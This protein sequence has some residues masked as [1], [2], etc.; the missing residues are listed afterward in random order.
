MGAVEQR[1][2]GAENRDDLLAHDG[3]DTDE[4]DADKGENKGVFHQG[5]SPAASPPL[6]GSGTGGKMFFLSK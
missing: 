2:D 1:G 4:N 6:V 3:N 5:L